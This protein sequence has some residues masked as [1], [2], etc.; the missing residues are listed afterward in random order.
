MADQGERVLIVD[1][2]RFFREA[3]GEVLEGAGIGWRAV[4]TGEE[5]LSA[6]EDES[7]GAV[8]LDLHLPGMD[9][10]EVLEQ[11]RERRP[12]LRVLILSASSDQEL[13]LD[14]L[15]L[16]ACDYL[17][18]PLHDEELVLAVRR[19]LDGF[20]VAADWQRMQGALASLVDGICAL[21]QEIA[22]L[23]GD[24]RDQRLHAGAAEAAAEV[25]RARKTS[26]MLVDDARESLHVV[27]AVGR[28]VAPEAMDSV[29]VGRGV[30][31]AVLAEGRP[32]LVQDVEGEP[33]F[34][35]DS[36]TEP[37]RY[38]TGSFA[39]APLVAGGRAI[40]V[41]CAT[42]R[43]DERPFG[44][45]DLALLRLL[46]HQVAE[47]VA[48]PALDPGATVELPAGPSAEETQAIR[49]EA[50]DPA[51]ELDAELARRICEALVSEVEP[52]RVLR[53]VLEPVS[54]L[55]HAS[56]SL[57]LL[58]GATGVLRCEAEI[59]GGGAASD[60]AQLATHRGLTG[61]VA[62]SGQMIASARPELD[63]RFDPEVDTP[64]DGSVG[65]L[66]CVPL[67][68][69]GKCVGVCRVFPPPAEDDAEPST[70]TG[71]VLSSALSAAVRNVLLYRSL[72]ESI[73]E[74]AEVRRQAQ[75]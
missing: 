49:G 35:A 37:D 38:E 39:L 3:I 6:A 61:L 65:P 7:L 25:L 33:R 58:D 56:V 74:V 34:E 75:R 15:R 69:R 57:Y 24:E 2:E 30:A 66:L 55:L 51:A 44:E 32:V 67:A 13:V 5:A 18:K 16:G 70:R 23:S 9:G 8:V 31:G 19:A 59:D 11:L 17:G 54:R 46:A 14:A 29:S 36:D 12:E 43:E 50:G 52:D 62:Q 68:L 27:A 40:G 1:D 72:V 71:E 64:A 63:A 53:A 21:S 28:R 41:L 45:P 4:A 47:L 73:E 20:T 60:R 10:L 22:E 42:D 48:P 26:L